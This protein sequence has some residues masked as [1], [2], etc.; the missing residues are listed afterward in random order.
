M[1]CTDTEHLVVHSRSMEQRWSGERR[2]RLLGPE[3]VFLCGAAAL[4][5]RLNL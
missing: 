1:L 2:C 5:A 4:R 3:H